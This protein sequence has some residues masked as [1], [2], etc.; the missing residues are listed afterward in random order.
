MNIVAQNKKAL[1]D[2]EILR[3]IEAGII[4][5]GNEVKSLRAKRGS[6]V[7]SFATIKDGELFLLNCNIPVYSH[8]YQKEEDTAFRSRKLLLHK[9]ELSK[10]IGEIST[11]GITVIPTKIYFNK[12]NLAKVEIGVARHRKAAGKKQVLKERDIARDTHRE[13]K[14]YR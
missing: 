12:K 11:K 5:T 4:L 6:L 1:F 9:K 14:K 7:G 8:A 13:L 3:K 2:Y 10:L